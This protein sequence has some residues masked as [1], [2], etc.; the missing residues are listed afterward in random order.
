MNRRNFLKLMMGAAG[1][2]MLDNIFPSRT[3][4][5]ELKRGYHIV[6]ISDL[7]L[8]WR[9]KSFPD[10]K[11]G[12][13]I[14]LQKEKILQNIKKWGDVKEA[15]LL[16]DFPARYGN[17]EEFLS[18]DKFMA[19]LPVPYYIAIGNHDYAYKDNP[20]KNGKLKRGNHAEKVKKLNAFK[21]RYKMPSLYYGRTIGKY[22][23]LYLA[24]DACGNLNVELSQA[25][26]EWMKEEIAN[27][28]ENPIIFFC[29]AP[30][31]NTLP[32]YNKKVN[33]PQTTAQPDEYLSKILQNAPKGSL[34]I[35]G[36]THTPV[37]N[38]CFADDAVNRYN[39]N[40]INIHNPTIDAKRL[41]TNSLYLFEDRIVLR[42]YDHTKDVWLDEFR[43]VYE[44][45]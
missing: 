33:K 26:L 14:F 13:K 11:K 34:W 32:Q 15:A 39:D 29:H 7:H 21:E 44:N 12:K 1:Y 22:R 43:R 5:A 45:K 4:G 20:G 6:L 8:P 16:G 38:T 24:P 28:R 25:Q 27:Y 17:E 2:V 37:T 30:L 42:T 23:L 31:M 18:V 3:E 35:S 19:K 10:A 40:I 41:C 9:S 36:H